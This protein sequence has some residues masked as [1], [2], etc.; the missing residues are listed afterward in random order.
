MAALGALDQTESRA[1]KTPPALPESPARNIPESPRRHAPG[2]SRSGKN[3]EYDQCG[4]HRNNAPFGRT[5]VS[6]SQ[7]H[8]PPCAA[9]CKSEIPNSGPCPKTDPAAPPPVCPCEKAL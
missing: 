8:P 7:I 1:Q 5:A 2:C 4:T 6:T 3:R 9:N